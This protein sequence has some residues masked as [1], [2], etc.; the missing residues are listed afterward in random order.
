MFSS[1]TMISQI[2]MFFQLTYIK[3]L[4]I[5][6]C[7]ECK[8]KS[9]YSYWGLGETVT[10][11]IQRI[12][13]CLSKSLVVMV[14]CSAV[15]CCLKSSF[16]VCKLGPSALPPIVRFRC[17][18]HLLHH[19]CL[20]PQCLVLFSLKWGDGGKKKKHNSKCERREES[21]GKV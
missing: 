8:L 19:C 6:N 7:E 18:P 17:I 15:L 14:S 1:N 16:Q 5:F 20:Q 9:S 21:K 10:R 4:H 12:Q 2:Y 11:N 13:S 3:L